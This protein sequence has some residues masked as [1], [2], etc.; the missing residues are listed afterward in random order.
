MRDPTIRHLAFRILQPESRQLKIEMRQPCDLVKPA[1]Y[2]SG[3]DLSSNELEIAATP[4]SHLLCSRV[5]S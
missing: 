3:A 1:F 2:S 4:V 5:P